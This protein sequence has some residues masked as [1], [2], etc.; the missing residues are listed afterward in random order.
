MKAIVCYKYG[1]PDVLELRE[2]EKPVATGNDVLVRVKAAAINP[3]DYHL[4]RGHGRI[5]PGVGLLRPK[6]KIPGTDLAGQVEAVGRDVKQFK[7]GDEVFCGRAGAFA[8]YVCVPEDRLVRK[9]ANL[10]FE[11]AAG[12]PV[13]ATTAL[14]ALRDWGRIRPGQRVLINGA[15]GGVG[16][17][18]VQIAKVFGAEVTGVCS[19]GNVDLVRSLGA[20]RVIDYGQEDFARGGQRYDLVLDNAGSRSLSDL[21]RVLVSNGTL[22]LNSGSGSVFRVLARMLEALLSSRFVSQKMVLRIAKLNKEDLLVLKDLIEAGKVT[23]VVDKRYSLSEVPEALRY[24]EE[25]H[26][27]GKVVITIQ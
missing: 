22:V 6:R 4:I 1:S 13:A 14:Q 9:P 2:V 7:P 17:F 18:A 25:G 19:T 24:L 8:E 21:R 20:D 10:T 16:T 12:V 15:S 5:M 11:Q 27:R 3:A 23:S 26:A